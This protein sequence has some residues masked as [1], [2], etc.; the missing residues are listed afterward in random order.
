MQDN[1]SVKK[2]LVSNKWMQKFFDL[3]NLK[4]ND[5]LDPV[6][7]SDIAKRIFED[8]KSFRESFQN[9]ATLVNKEQW[10]FFI[11]MFDGGPVII[12]LYKERKYEGERAKIND[13]R[14]KNEEEIKNINNK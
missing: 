13:S 12:D 10:N 2:Y 4:S 9:Y 8:Q 5:P 7:N 11:K 6:D 1:S 14:S 3:I